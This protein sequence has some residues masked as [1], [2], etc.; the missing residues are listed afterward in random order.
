MN[1]DEELFRVIN[2]LAGQS[3]FLD[4]SM[5]ELSREGNLLFPGLLLV[6]YWGWTNWREARIAGPSLAL[7][8]GL[9]DSI[10][11]QL[12]ILIGRSRPCQMLAYV[13]KLVGCGGT[14]S[15]P[16]NHAVN[17]AAA[18]AFL[19]MLYPATAWITWPLVGLI[20]LSRVY[21]GAHYV[22]DVF[23]GWIIGIVLGSSVGFLLAK[24][25]WL[26][27]ENRGVTISAA[28]RDVL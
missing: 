10:G 13:H 16:S 26:G 8:I 2:G 18:A 11:G 7:L 22:T 17:S 24:S 19:H 15:M 23:G 3:D 5:Y 20:G 28:E 12:K 6:L 27:R 25:A 4:W 21:L 14:M 1:W 9:S